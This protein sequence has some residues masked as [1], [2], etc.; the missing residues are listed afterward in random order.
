MADSESSGRRDLTKRLAQ[1][2]LMP[3]VATAASAAA[4]YVAKKG[5][6]LFEERVLPK[7][8]EVAGGAAGA[9]SEVPARAK[10]AAGG[11]GDLAEGLTTRVR[12]TV[13]GGGSGGGNGRRAGLSRDELERH[14]KE[15]AEARASRRT[16]TRRSR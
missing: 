7:L 6:Q 10:Q 13:G 5:P 14:L 2:A 3:I 16:S 15:R 11:A 9:A 12:E 8:K 4:G 1:R